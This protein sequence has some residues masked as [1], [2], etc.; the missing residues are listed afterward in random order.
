[1]GSM[2]ESLSEAEFSERQ[3]DN[4]SFPSPLVGQISSIQRC[5]GSPSVRKIKSKQQRTRTIPTSLRL[6]TTASSLISV[7]FFSGIIFGWAP[8]KVV[9]K[10]EGQY[11]EYCNGYQ[12][13]CAEQ[14]SRFN[15]IFT[16]AQFFLSFAS[17]PVGFF[18]DYA[19]KPFHFGFAAVF[20]VG[21]LLLFA[22]ADSKH[23]DNF[24]LAYSLLALGGCITTLGAYPASFLLPHHQAGILAG[25]AC[26]FDASSVIFAIFLRLYLID[27]ST[28]SRT[29][30]FTWYA[31]VCVFVYS[32]LCYCWARLER[33]QWQDSLARDTQREC[34]SDAAND[35]QSPNKIDEVQD[36]HLWRIRSLRMHKLSLGNQLRTLDFA[37]VLIFASVHMLRCNFYIE[38]VN[39]I[40][41]TMGDHDAF[42]ANIFSFVLPAGVVFVPLI[43]YTVRELGVVHTLHITNALGVLFGVLLLVPSLNIQVINFAIF[44]CFRAY[45]YATMSTF[46]AVTFGV[47]TMGRL[48]GCTFTSAALVTLLQYPAAS[49]A[50]R[51]KTNGF[52]MI[53]LI[54]LS[55]CLAPTALTMSYSS[56]TSKLFE[57]LAPAANNE[58]IG[59]KTSLLS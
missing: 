40:L 39:E 14:L 20:Q 53:N 25:I 9:L 49:I 41:L 50:E 56:R 3:A 45:L 37:L 55:I 27:A 32:L 21:G 8:L 12:S 23:A 22:K 51:Q 44:A 16:S 1:M 34:S 28:F 43:E 10:Q 38:T 33:L 26:L 11:S 2:Y 30:V 15:A 13:S 19:P 31:I 46:I 54:M 59:E 42:Y 52:T 18:L 5:Y 58:Q 35:E 29:N 24:V 7:C 47:S 6:L 36:P 57:Q 17:L 48:I 4:L